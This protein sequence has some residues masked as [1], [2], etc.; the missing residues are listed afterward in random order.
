MRLHLISGLPRAGST[1]LAAIL[2]Q[3]P[4]MHAAIQSPVWDV[5]S[6]ALRAMSAREGALFI[7]DAQRERILRAVVEAYYAELS[8]TRVISIRT[9]TGARWSRRWRSC[10]PHLRGRRV[11]VGAGRPTGPGGWPG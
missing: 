5:F 11:S 8:P 4:G 3:N 1:L 2:R 9:G 7:S 6:N 10:F